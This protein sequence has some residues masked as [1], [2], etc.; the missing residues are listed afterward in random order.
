M[1]TS[2]KKIIPV[3]VFD[4]SSSSI[5]GAH[6]LVPSHFEKNDKV[7]VL[8]SLRNISEPKEDLNIEKFVNDSILN[9]ENTISTIKKADNHHPKHIQVLLASPWFVSQTRT[10]SYN[11][12]T[13]FLCTEKLIDSLIDKE[14]EYVM[15][16][17]MERFGSMGGEGL[18]IEKQISQIKLNG[19]ATAKP[20]GKKTQSVELF[21]VVTVSPKVIIDR[22]K[23]V[24]LKNYGTTVVKF[25]T[26][27][28][29]T[30]I[31]SRDILK[32]PS[33][34]LLVDVGE[35]VTDIACIK[36][37]L[38]LYQHS[39]PVGTHQL[40]RSLV[41][42]GATT[43]TEASAVIESFRLAKLS[44]IMTSNVQKSLDSFGSMWGR[45][46]Q[47]LIEG[48]QN[49]LKLPE[50]TYITSDYRFGDFFSKLLKED[51]FFQHTTGSITPNVLPISYEMLSLHSSSLD[52]DHL[53]ETLIIGSLF[54]SLLLR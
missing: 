33:E 52:K 2:H 27:P 10:I 32:L 12:T 38:F 11:K 43:L 21:L 34:L 48:G 18:I 24:F 19:Y 31:V 26:S 16:H 51:L 8:A 25:T 23:E 13:D 47:E 37:D 39:F 1:A 5:G 7:S 17:D 6:V 42:N 3:A 46:F 30:Y 20:F 49:T 54:V 15:N 29:A 50:N 22:I 45:S 4:I 35:E 28:Y 41:G 44:A 9:L 40:Y 53:D 36:N 14:I